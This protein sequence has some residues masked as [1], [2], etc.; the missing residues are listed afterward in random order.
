[1]ETHEHSAAPTRPSLPDHL[2]ASV[3]TLCKPASGQAEVKLTLKNGRTVYG[4]VVRKDGVIVSKGGRPVYAA[5]ELRFRPSE[6]VE[7]SAY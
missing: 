5:Q 4:I 3:S 6:I 7:V 1:M 2:L